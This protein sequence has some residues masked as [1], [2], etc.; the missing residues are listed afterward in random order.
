MESSTEAKFNDFEWADTVKKQFNWMAFFFGFIWGIFNKAWITLLDVPITIFWVI[1]YFHSAFI[2]GE[3]IIFF[4]ILS[5]CLHLWF[6]FKGNSWSLRKIKYKSREDFS[7]FQRWVLV[8][9]LIAFL[10][11]ITASE[12]FMFVLEGIPW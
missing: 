9:I 12:M 4:Y 7:S 3:A 6:G 5:F 1:E 2:P 8:M 11:L 10:L